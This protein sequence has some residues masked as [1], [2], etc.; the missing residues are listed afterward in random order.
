[1]TSGLF[2]TLEGG[3]GGGKTTQ[4]N[5]LAEYLKNKGHKVLT[6]REPGGTPEAE[7]IRNLLVQRQSGEWSPMAET[8]M[9]FAARVEHI[10]R[11]IKPALAEGRTVISD[12]FTDSTYAYQ[13]AGREIGFDK[14]AE[15]EKVALDGFK[16][17]VT[18][19]LDL[20]PKIG[21]E[22]STRRLSAESLGL[23][24]TEDRFENMELVFHQRLREAFLQI[25]ERE[26]D[27]CH[28]LDANKDVQ[29]VRD[30]M[31]SIID[32]VLTS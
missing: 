15:L 4:L 9:M 7:K 18:F 26:P 10:E 12:R 1:M 32:G 29:A 30:D 6:T 25:A 14:I 3:E 27:R 17:D 28:V 13:G 24:Q 5:Y 31:Q 23:K 2:I 22:R 8:L 19:I 20:D 21:L 11:V 16:P